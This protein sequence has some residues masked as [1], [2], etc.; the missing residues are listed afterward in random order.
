MGKLIAIVGDSAVGKTSAAEYLQSEYNFKI[1]YSDQRC[2]EYNR[3]LA[4]LHSFVERNE[5]VVV[6]DNIEMTG[7]Y[8]IKNM[9]GIVIEVVKPGQEPIT[10][11]DHMIT[12]NMTPAFYETMKNTFALCL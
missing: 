11:F 8:D 1:F 2:M 12:N 6:P 10:P 3:W 9:G 7:I 5:T 4:L